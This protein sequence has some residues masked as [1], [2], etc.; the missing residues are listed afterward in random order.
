MSRSRFVRTPGRRS[1]EKAPQVSL[2]G[3]SRLF[4]RSPNLPRTCARSTIGPARLNFRVRDRLLAVFV[5]VI[6]ARA[7]AADVHRHGVPA[8]RQVR[9]HGA[10]LAPLVYDHRL[11]NNLRPVRVVDGGGP[12]AIGVD[13]VCTGLRLKFSSYGLAVNYDEIDLGE[14]PFSIEIGHCDPVLVK[15][16]A[17]PRQKY[18]GDFL[19]VLAF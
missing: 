5:A 10:K 11:Q 3:F 7:A 17:G 15:Y 6:H 9:H 4:R 16:D 19:A 8:Q 14:F 12:S 1:K 2:R 18:T 13:L